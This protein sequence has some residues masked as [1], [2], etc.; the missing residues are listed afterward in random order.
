MKTIGWIPSGVKKTPL[1]TSTKEVEKKEEV[2]EEKPKTNKKTT[3][4]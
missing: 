1:P 2:K 4:K 3:K